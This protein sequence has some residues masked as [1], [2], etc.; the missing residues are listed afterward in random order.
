M[1]CS[2]QLGSLGVEAVHVLCLCTL[3]ICCRNYNVQKDF[4]RMKTAGVF[5]S[6]NPDGSVGE[7]W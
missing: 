7:G 2:G 6:V 1:S 5:Q 4:D 3:K